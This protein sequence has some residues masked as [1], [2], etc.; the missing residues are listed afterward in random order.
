MSKTLKRKSKFSVIDSD[1]SDDEFDK[2]VAKKKYQRKETIID[3]KT[4]T[5]HKKKK[6][7]FVNSSLWNCVVNETF[8]EESRAQE[9]Q[10]E[11][12]NG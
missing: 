6:W 3:T 1:A 7:V 9:V 8:F 11:L 10:S 2:L 12:R 4:N 5:R